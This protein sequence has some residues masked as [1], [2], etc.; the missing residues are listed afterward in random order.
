MVL[1]LASSGYSTQRVV[2]AHISVFLVTAQS[3]CVALLLRVTI[4]ADTLSVVI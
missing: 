3:V 2:Y 1:A 4:A